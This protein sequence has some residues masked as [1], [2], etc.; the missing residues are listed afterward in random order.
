MKFALSIPVLVSGLLVVSLA[1]A[2]A[3]HGATRGTGALLDAQDLSLRFDHPAAEWTEAL[4]VGNGRLG[5]MVFGG[6]PSERIQLNEDTIWAKGP[7][8]ELPENAGEVIDEARALFFAGRPAAGQAL[9]QEML[10]A[11]ISPRSHQTLGDLRLMYVGGGEDAA[12]APYGRRLDLR[13]AVATS[14]AQGA[15][16]APPTTSSRCASPRIAR[17]RWTWTW[18][19]IAPPPSPPAPWGPIGW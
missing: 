12:A 6:F 1:C 13:T 2:S 14:F 5:A 19:S 7:V 17:G 11:R 15:L 10:P 8:P 3:P 9:V 18:R 16:E 4:P